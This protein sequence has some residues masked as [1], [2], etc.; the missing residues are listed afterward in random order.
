M[1]ESTMIVQ[2]ARLS[3]FY[4]AGTDASLAGIVFMVLG[5]GGRGVEHSVKADAKA[6]RAA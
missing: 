6:L 2:L 3:F 1:T 4:R 5:W